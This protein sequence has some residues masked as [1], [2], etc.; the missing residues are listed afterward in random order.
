M[1]Q[2]IKFILFCN[3]TVLVSDGLSVQQQ[4]FKNVHRATGICQTDTAVCLVAGTRWPSERKRK[5]NF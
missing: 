5:I 2:G 3:D 4:E 1:H